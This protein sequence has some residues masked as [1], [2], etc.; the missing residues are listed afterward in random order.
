[1]TDETYR[2]SI[3]F[4]PKT[5]E[6]ISSS[7]RELS[8]Q[9]FSDYSVAAILKIDVDFARRLIGERLFA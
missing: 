5:S 3:Q 2:R 7:A 1:V 9:G 6:Q 4:S 8:A